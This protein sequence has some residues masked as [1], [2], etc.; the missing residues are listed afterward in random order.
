MDG[1]RDS[2]HRLSPRQLDCLRLVAAG[3]TTLQIAA[4][5]G[6]SN[7]TVDQ[8]VADACVRLGARTR[9]EAVVKSVRLGLISDEP[10][11]I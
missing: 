11:V 7:R 1:S 8:Y 5:L 9:I 3:R 10:S 4:E 6:I 2:G